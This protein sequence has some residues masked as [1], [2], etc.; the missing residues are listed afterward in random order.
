[1]FNFCA[2]INVNTN[3]YKLLYVEGD[4]YTNVLKVL[5]VQLDK[6]TR[7]S[8]YIECKTA[9]WANGALR[10]SVALFLQNFPRHQD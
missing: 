3:I 7:V 10:F 9:F 4:S 1:M 6:S 5:Y 8:V 2:D